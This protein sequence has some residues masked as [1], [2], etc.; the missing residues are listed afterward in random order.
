MNVST[1]CAIAEKF[2]NW[3]SDVL[4]DSEVYADMGALE[5]VYDVPGPA[6]GPTVQVATSHH[7]LDACFLFGFS[8]QT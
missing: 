4:T 3:A 5:T 1:V 7:V 2:S 6:D 8:T